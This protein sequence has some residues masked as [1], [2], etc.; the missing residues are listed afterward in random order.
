MSMTDGNAAYL[1][2]MG[3]SSL[4]LSLAGGG[5]VQWVM[6]L[7]WVVLNWVDDKRG[8]LEMPGN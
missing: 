2:S 4:E 5:A 6:K 1:N 3:V 7:L 8:D